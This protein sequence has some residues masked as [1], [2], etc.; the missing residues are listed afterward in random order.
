VRKEI[1]PEGYVQYDRGVAHFLD[2]CL[3]LGLLIVACLA[4]GI[5]IF[6]AGWWIGSLLFHHVL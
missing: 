1:G 4:A 2:W 5:L 6:G 3:G